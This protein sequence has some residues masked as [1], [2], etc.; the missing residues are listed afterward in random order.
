MACARG[1]AGAL[2]SVQAAAPVVVRLKWYCVHFS[3]APSAVAAAAVAMWIG[4]LL[5]RLA[6]LSRS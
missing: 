5:P 2:A 6:L 4:A 3:P 1:D